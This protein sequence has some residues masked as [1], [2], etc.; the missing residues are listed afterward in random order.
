M[1]SPTAAQGENEATSCRRS[2]SSQ[3]KSEVEP[4]HLFIKDTFNNLSLE[5][6]FNTAKINHDI[7]INYTSISSTPV[8]PLK[9]L[10]IKLDTH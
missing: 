4:Q 3:V 6:L 10:T 2:W 9:Y 5:M 8:T 7:F 1:Y